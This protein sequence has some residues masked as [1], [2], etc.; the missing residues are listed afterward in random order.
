MKPT[1][2]VDLFRAT[3][4]AVRVE[5]KPLSAATEAYV[6]V[7]TRQAANRSVETRLQFGWGHLL[8]RNE[9][10]G[11]LAIGVAILE[12]MHIGV[13]QFGLRGEFL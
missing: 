13:P 10:P 4:W 6:P 5:T 8:L 9:V 11:R 2:E 3:L 1:T 12:H 7:N